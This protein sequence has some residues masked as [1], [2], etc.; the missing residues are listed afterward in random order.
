MTFGSTPIA[1]PIV[2]GVCEFASPRAGLVLGAAACLLAAALGATA[3][4]RTP[5]GERRHPRPVQ[6]NWAAYQQVRLPGL[7]EVLKAAP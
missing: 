2:G 3:V 7:T 5:P 4:T 1:G 6:M